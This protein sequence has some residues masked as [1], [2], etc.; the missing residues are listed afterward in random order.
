MMSTTPIPQ[1]QPNAVSLDDLF[2]Q[3]GEL[4]TQLEIATGKLQIINQQIAQILG[5]Q[6]IK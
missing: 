1:V 5:P 3:K 2:R 4:Q 6:T